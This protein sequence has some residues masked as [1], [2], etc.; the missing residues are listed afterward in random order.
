MTAC[1]KYYG[2]IWNLLLPLRN[3][4]LPLLFLFI[5]VVLCRFSYLDLLIYLCS[6]MQ[7]SVDLL[8]ILLYTLYYMTINSLTLLKVEDSLSCITIILNFGEGHPYYETNARIYNLTSV[9]QITRFLLED[10]IISSRIN[11]RTGN[12]RRK[13][14]NG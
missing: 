7:I 13:R 9:W 6:F 1:S 8:Y 10:A 5:Y 2:F 12:T 4:F 11:S 3:F 14:S